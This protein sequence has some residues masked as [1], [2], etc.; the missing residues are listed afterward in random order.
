MGS[1][2]GEKWG[3]EKFSNKKPA[4]ITNE[5]PDN[6][7]AKAG[8]A[9]LCP[10]RPPFDRN[11]INALTGAF[12]MYGRIMAIQARID[13]MKARNERDKVIGN[14]FG[15]YTEYDFRVQANNIELCVQQLVN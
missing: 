6:E 8:T 15:T 7:K 1:S 14:T 3:N 10:G 13:G 5:I 4:A 12:E 9:L 2:N 11:D